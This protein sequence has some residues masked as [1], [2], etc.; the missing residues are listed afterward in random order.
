MLFSS[1]LHLYMCVLKKKHCFDCYA[2]VCRYVGVQ[3]FLI[4]RKGTQTLSK[5]RSL[6]ACF[7]F[8]NPSNVEAIFLQLAE[9]WQ[10]FS[11]STHV[12]RFQSS[13]AS[14]CIC[15][16]SHK[17]HK[18]LFNYAGF[19]LFSVWDMKELVNSNMWNGGLGTEN[20]LKEYTLQ[21]HR[22]SN[23]L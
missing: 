6:S 7:R 8:F 15:Q 21:K 2:S 16:I 4:I 5:S 3:W 19:T 9:K 18:C 10:E 17:Q 22:S 11:Q 13:F 14:F 12:P 20:S 23:K 1:N